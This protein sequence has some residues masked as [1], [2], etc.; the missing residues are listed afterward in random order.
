MNRR[1]LLHALATAAG[2]TALIAGVRTSLTDGHLLLTTNGTTWTDTIETSN[3]FVQGVLNG[4]AKMGS[5]YYLSEAFLY[6]DT[7]TVAAPATLSTR[8]ATGGVQNTGIATDGTYLV[9]AGISSRF[10]FSTD[11]GATWTA[12][13]ST[14]GYTPQG[15]TYAAGIWVGVGRQ[16]TGL[17]ARTWY[18]TT[19]SATAWTVGTITGSGVYPVA[20]CYGA[21]F[22]A[23]GGNSTTSQ[24]AWWSTDGMTWTAG[25]ISGGSSLKA[26]CYH[27][28]T[29]VGVGVGGSISTSADGGATW[30]TRTSGVTTDLNSI[31]FA[32]NLFIVAGNSGVILT[33]PDGTTWTARTS[34][35][36]DNLTIAG[37]L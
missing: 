7:A 36:T 28:G 37:A 6:T 13:G 15:A 10:Y 14:T 35:T 11:Q 2:Y 3:V 5:N 22:V 24:A 9:A 12:S 34:G 32:S 31:V 21:R 1:I 23:V 4:Y 26:I 33:S 25:T 19:P 16:N 30:T 8:N 18:T 27:G 17:N 29:Y 20:V